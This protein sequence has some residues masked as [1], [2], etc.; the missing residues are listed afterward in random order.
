MNGYIKHHYSNSFYN[1]DRE[2]NRETD[3]VSK[4]YI[5]KIP[6]PIDKNYLKNQIKNKKNQKIQK[7]SN[8]KIDKMSLTEPSTIDEDDLK[9]IKPNL[10]YLSGDKNNK[11]IKQIL[12]KNSNEI[13]KEEKSLQKLFNEFNYLTLNQDINLKNDYDN[14][15]LKNHIFRNNS[16]SSM[17]QYRNNY[18]IQNSHYNNYR[19]SNPNLTK[20]LSKINNLSSTNYKIYNPIQDHSKYNSIYD[21]QSRKQETINN[22][23]N[24]LYNNIDYYKYINQIKKSNIPYKK[25]R[26]SSITKQLSYINL[27]EQTKESGKERRNKSMSPNPLIYTPNINSYQNNFFVQYTTPRINNNLID[28][29][30][31]DKINESINSINLSIL[32]DD[33]IQG[34]DLDKNFNFNQNQDYKNFKLIQEPLPLYDNSDIINPLNSTLKKMKKNIEEFNI[35]NYSL[36]KKEE[37]KVDFPME[38]TLNNNLYNKYI[39]NKNLYNQRGI[40]NNNQKNFKNQINLNNQFTNTQNSNDNYNN[41]EHLTVQKFL[42]NQNLYNLKTINNETKNEQKIQKN[43]NYQNL[44]NNQN[45]L[46]IKN[47]Y[48]QNLNQQNNYKKTNN[49]NLNNQFENNLRNTDFQIINNQNLIKNIT[50]PPQNIINNQLKN[51]ENIL[52][53]NNKLISESNNIKLNP[54]NNQKKLELDK[55]NK[56][57]NNNLKNQNETN[58]ESNKEISN[59]KLNLSDSIILEVSE[60][61]EISKIDLESTLKNSITISQLKDLNSTPEKAYEQKIELGKKEHSILENEKNT[62]ENLKLSMIKNDNENKKNQFKIEN[63]ITINDP[64]LEDSDE[65]NNIIF[66]EIIRTAKLREL[67]DKKEKEKKFK[68][69]KNNKIIFDEEQ[70]IKMIYKEDDEISKIDIIHLKN[71]KKEKLKERNINI[72]FSLLKSYNK[73]KPIIKPFKKNEI[74]IDNNFIM[75]YSSSSDLEYSSDDEEQKINEDNF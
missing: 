28:N 39:N 40:N 4:S 15:Y 59:E 55:K 47:M 45:N 23:N 14:I 6:K 34:F 72:Y 73:P 53:Q 63:S 67:K 30:E 52:S 9:N 21:Y 70:N 16:N 11:N 44:Y 60:N 33:I 24:N 37:T 35:E 56:E 22:Y 2:I 1:S 26:S 61:K 29:E 19:M 3:L 57:E 54:N 12:F 18:P 25:I 43:P 51:Q 27:N 38:F 20:N 74:L 49:Q 62:F 66:R 10:Q 69:N 13:K 46:E 65:E 64:L 50:N 42:N 71:K 75:D 17:N 36:E 68:Q 8:L 48:P 58:E 7:I 5:N 32:A 31:F 41:N